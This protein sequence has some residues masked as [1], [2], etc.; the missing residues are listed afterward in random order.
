MKNK[1]GIDCRLFGSK[2]AGIGR[3]IENLIFNLISL[4]QD[5]SWVLFFFDKQQVSEFWQ[6]LANF[7]N[8]QNKLQNLEK[9]IKIVL[10]NIKHYS[11]KEQIYLPRIFKKENLDLLHV[12]HFNAPCFYQG[13]LILTIHDLLW[14]EMKGVH[15]TTLPVWQYYLKYWFYLLVVRIN[16]KKAK[17]II[18]PAQTTKKTIL[19]IYPKIKKK[20]AVITEGVFFK[21]KSDLKEIKFNLP[22]KYLLYVG[23]L[24][25]HKNIDLILRSLKKIDYHLVIV[26]TRGAFLEKFILKLKKMD[27]SKKVLILTKLNDRELIYCYQNSQALVQPSLSEGFGLTPLEAMFYQTL[28][29]TSDIDIFKEVCGNIPLYFDPQSDTSFLEA[30]KK[31][32][33]VDRQ[34]KLKEAKLWVKQYD[35]KKMSCEIYNLYKICLNE[36]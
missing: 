30:V 6:K 7:Q 10:V 15:V 32:E 4:H 17:K 8:N 3:Y 22:N 35:F 27:L 19:K 1:I 18:V 29:L 26:T 9:N 14:H 13:K 31:M 34:K 25:P 23:S 36:K 12:P 21:R 28:V 2:H 5:E 16:L 20:I 33:R 11:L 24:Y